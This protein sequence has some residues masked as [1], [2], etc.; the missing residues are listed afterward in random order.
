[1]QI[2]QSPLTKKITIVQG[3]VQVQERQHKKIVSIESWSDAFLI[4]I[5]IYCTV[6]H[7]KL[8]QLLKY[9]NTIRTA[10]KRCGPFNFGWRDYVEQFRLKMDMDVEY[11]LMFVNNINGNAQYVNKTQNLTNNNTI[12]KCYKC[13]AFNYNGHY[14]KRNCPYSLCWLLSF[15]CLPKG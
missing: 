7:D 6:H 5:S 11:W 9:M 2:L 3:E 14:E 12:Y 13:F 15:N 8:H 1:M 4:F 10:A